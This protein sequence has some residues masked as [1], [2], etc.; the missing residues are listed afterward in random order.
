M[1]EGPD[2][3]GRL[4]D[5]DARRARLMEQVALGDHAAFSALYDLI[6]PEVYGLILRVLRDPAQSEEVAQEALVTV[7]RDAPRYDR[8]RGSVLTW[9]LTIAHRRAVDR[10]RSSS[11]ARAREELVG[12]R[13]LATTASPASDLAETR[14][15]H[16]QVGRAL[17][18]LTDIQRAAIE[19]AYYNG[20]T[21][22]QIAQ[23]LDLPLGTVKTRIRDA[24]VRLRDELGVER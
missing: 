8:A 1:T 2:R 10:V 3:A 11:A 13:D 12:R 21:H 14:L 23:L 20:Y 18:Q 24:L 6:A 4:T 17:A 22:R 16:A 15:D 19:L 9:A 7:W 5:V